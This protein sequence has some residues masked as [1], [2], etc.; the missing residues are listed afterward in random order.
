MQLLKVNEMFE[1]VPETSILLV[2]TRQAIMETGSKPGYN[3]SIPDS[4]NNT[5]A[6]EHHFH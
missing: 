5:A 2:S 6:T 3:K 1:F 4:K